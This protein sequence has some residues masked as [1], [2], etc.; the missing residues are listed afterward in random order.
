MTLGSSLALL[1]Y[2]VIMKRQPSRNGV[3]PDTESSRSMILDFPGTRT[4]R[5][6]FLLFISFLF[7]YSFVQQ[8]KTGRRW[9]QLENLS[10]DSQDC[11]TL[12]SGSLLGRVSIDISNILVGRC[13]ELNVYHSHIHILKPKFLMH[14]YLEMETL[15]GN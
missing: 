8:P 10:W 13:Y 1:P 6:E 4:V 3:S 5:N 2:E 11:Y 12:D 14:W 15:G 7:Y 9:V